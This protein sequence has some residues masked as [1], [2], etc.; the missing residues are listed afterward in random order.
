MGLPAGRAPVSPE[1]YLAFERSA[2]ERHEY[3]DGEIFAMSGGTLE[4]SLTAANLGGELGTALERRPCRVLN[5]NMRVRIP[6][7]NHYVYPDGVVVC[8]KPLFDDEV[9]DTLMNPVLVVEVL[10]D[11]SE[12]YDRG[13]K[14]AQYRSLPSMKEYVIASQKEPRLEVFTRQADESWVL[15]IYGAGEVARLSSID[16]EIAVDRAYLRVFEQE[17]EGAA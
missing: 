10:S 13:D 4:H 16:C 6:E 9:R 5:S 17:G 2:K 1:E 7:R 3:A 11:S 12:R 14:F 8:G 15:R